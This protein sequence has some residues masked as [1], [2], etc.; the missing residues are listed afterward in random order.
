MA[1]LFLPP[2]DS[3]TVKQQS[4]V[5]IPAEQRRL[6]GLQAN[7]Y[8]TLAPLSTALEQSKSRA[9]GLSSGSDVFRSSF[10]P[11]T[12]GQR[13]SGIRNLTEVP[14]PGD[15]D[16]AGMR[17]AVQQSP[18]FQGHPLQELFR[19]APASNATAMELQALGGELLAMP[20]AG[21]PSSEEMAYQNYTAS[22]L[23]QAMQASMRLRP[24]ETSLPGTIGQT[25]QGMA[26]TLRGATTDYTGR[27]TGLADRARYLS[28]L[29]IAPIDTGPQRA[30]FDTA[31]RPINFDRASAARAFAEAEKPLDTASL[32]DPLNYAFSG[33][34]NPNSVMA[35]LRTAAIRAGHSPDV[36]SSGYNK[37]LTGATREYGTGLANV[38]ANAELQRR[39]GMTQAA[40][41]MTQAEQAAAMAELGRRTGMTQAATGVTQ[42]D[43]TQAMNE[44][45][46]KMTNLQGLQ[47]AGGINADIYNAQAGQLAP[48]YQFLMAG[49][50]AEAGLAGLQRQ[51]A[52]QEAG[53]PLSLL[54]GYPINVPGAPSY[55]GGEISSRQNQPTIGSQVGAGLNQALMMSVLGPTAFKNIGG[56]F[57][58][59][60]SGIISGSVGNDTLAG[61]GASPDMLSSAAGAGG[62]YSA[63]TSL[64]GSGATAGAGYGASMAMG[65]WIAELLYGKTSPKVSLLRAWL[66]GKHRNSLATKLYLKYGERFAA[67]LRQHPIWQRPVRMLFDRWVK[68]AEQELCPTA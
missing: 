1:G 61:M 12:L 65:C 58:G 10:N 44:L 64:F 53:V 2:A 6:L 7:Q 13:L 28:E 8:Q 30:A 21:Q 34:G 68:L 47:T 3:M 4:D 14:V 16:Y 17:A 63:L 42:A 40:A 56:M 60:D 38:L 59:G 41:G 62:L 32:M 46:N 52:G 29:G 43:A 18:Y 57:G 66:F 26:D 19:G 9:L 35:Q 33:E 50:Q 31:G 25:S 51:L 45:R 36:A 5:T 55:P 22:P 49:P 48:L 20:P 11:Q 67:W 24:Q 23:V 54:Q 39:Q 27:A 37:L 15:P